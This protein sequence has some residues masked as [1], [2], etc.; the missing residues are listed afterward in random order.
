MSACIISFNVHNCQRQ[1]QAARKCQPEFIPRK[2]RYRMRLGGLL[3]PGKCASPTQ[4]LVCFSGS[5]QMTRKKEEASQEH[6]ALCAFE[7][8]KAKFGEGGVQCSL[9]GHGWSQ[10]VP[11]TAKNRL[12]GCLLFITLQPTLST[13]LPT[14]WEQEPALLPLHSWRERSWLDLSLS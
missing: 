1:G 10:P 6:S 7:R 14:P 5:L 13:Y 9:P 3:C 4:T 8:L 11:P 12:R 2:P